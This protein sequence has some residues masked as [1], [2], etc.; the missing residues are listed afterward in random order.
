MITLNRPSI[1]LLIPLLALSAV[2]VIAAPAQQE[3]LDQSRA[4]EAER[5][6]RLGEERVETIVPP[7]PSADLPADES[8]HFHISHI[9]I[10]NQVERFRFL[11]R[12]AR[13]Y[14]DKELSLS[15]INKLI[16]AMN[17]SLMARGFSTSRIVVPEQNLSS[18]E[19]RLVLLV[20]YIGTV[21]FADGSDALY[22]K[23]LFPLHEGGILNVRD[24]EQGI[25][26]AKRL[27]S[28]DISVQLLPSDQQQRTDVVLTVKRGKNFY[29]T[30]SVDDSGL[31][32]T[33]KLQWYT[34]IGID[35]PFHKN[36]MLRI[37]M[38]L[39]GACDGYE[40]GT[41][42]HNISYTY[43]YGRHTFSF[44]YQRSK[45]HQTVESIPY[46]FISAG[47]S[48]IS[49]L[50]WDYV[51]HRSAAMKTSMDI[52]LRKRN[53]HNFLNGVELPIQA[54]HQTSMEVGYAERL[55][56]DRD[57]LYFRIAHRFGLGW[58]GAQKEKPYDDAPKTLY[59]MWLLDVDFVHPFE[60]CHRPATFTTSFHGQYTMDD[61]RLYG[62]DMISMG[63]R[64]TVRG[65]DGEVTL[66]GTN[67]W[68]LRNELSTR[69]PKQKAELYF[70]LDVGAVY[71]YGTEVYNGHVIAG[72]VLGLRGAMDALSYDVFAAK[73]IQNPEGFR[74]PDVTYGFSLGVRF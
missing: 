48:N 68:Y 52:R 53:S 32:D 4:Q 9:R 39:D 6:N 27:P 44:S 45:Y 59:R 5:Q 21:R 20:G 64:Y 17:Q 34:S 71:G 42:G 3:Q 70:G 47:D 30:I 55:Y 60:F 18:G 19:L 7:P 74:T 37:G 50:S 24:I 73:P 33:G 54:M 58:L 25:E 56:I 29:G 12:I 41:R 1:L 13:P 69:F 43:P 66:M 72:T 8:V 51:L 2:P 16:H 15:D 36:D 49:T 65:F 11:E 31:E 62:V 38:N 46:N 57:T 67:G 14:K 28:Q 10:E 61:M 23:N 40:K 22:W 26:Q 35:Q 63:N